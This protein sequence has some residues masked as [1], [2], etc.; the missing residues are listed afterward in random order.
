MELPQG[1]RATV[2]QYAEV[3]V[4]DMQAQRVSDL[5]IPRSAV[6]RKGGLPLVYAVGDDGMTRLRVV[7]L[8]ENLGTGYCIVLAGLRE[9]DVIVNDPPPGM[10]AGVS[11]KEA[12][13]KL[14]SVEQK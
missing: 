4:P 2:G 8:G 10:T 6:T 3:H 14:P 12:L 9:G 1:S 7:R 5:V 11:V 13:G